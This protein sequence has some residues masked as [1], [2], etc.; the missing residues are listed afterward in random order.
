MI[1]WL[2]GILILSLVLILYS[3]FIYPWI[4]EVLAKSKSFSGP[5]FSSEELPKIA[6][7]FAAYNEEKVIVA[8]LKNLDTLDYPSDKLEIHVGLDHP[9]DDTAKLIEANKPSRFPFKVHHFTKRQGKAN[10]LNKMFNQKIKTSDY[11]VVVMMD[12]NIILKE[13]CLIELLKYFKN[14]SL[15]LVGAVIQNT[16]NGQSEIAIQ[17]RFY[18]SKESQIKVNEGLAFGATIG[19]F[20]ACYAIRSKHIK[21]I[22]SNFLMEDFYLSMHVL[23]E[24]AL[25]MTNPEAVV[26]EDLPGSVKEEFK[27]KRRISTGNFQNLKAYAGL[28]LSRPWPVGFAFFSHK[29]LRWFTPFFVLLAVMTTSLLYIFY[30]GIAIHRIVFVLMM[31]NILLPLV[32]LVLKAMNISVNLL[33][34]HRYFLSMNIAM[35]LGFIDWVR[36]VKTNIWKPTERL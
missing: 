24:G 36:G 1:T 32:D 25:C 2:Y 35:F 30:P 29:I 28:L 23:E 6:I 4:M 20:G 16:I 22:P 14:P 9:D 33:R 3:Y 13:N 19:A 15:G 10:V 26:Y 7:V 21:T 31:L 11:E 8:K 34:L 12:A 17:E 18:I 5:H 27:R